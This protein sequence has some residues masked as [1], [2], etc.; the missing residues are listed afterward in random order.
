MK[1]EKQNGT[2]LSDILSFYL[3]IIN[4]IK[5]SRKENAA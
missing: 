2:D 1:K 4:K 3:D 5:M